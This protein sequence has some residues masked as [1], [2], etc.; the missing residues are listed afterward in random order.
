MPYQAAAAELAKRPGDGAFPF[1][2]KRLALIETADGL[3]LRASFWH[4]PDGQAAQG[5][6]L[7]LQ[8][9]TEFIEKYAEVIAELLER[10][11]AV[12]AFDW[13]GQGLSERQVGN[14]AKGHVEDFDDYL[15]DLAAI[16][17]EMALEAC[18]RPW[19]ML[20]HSMGGG[21]ALLALASGPSPFDRA[22]LSAPLVGLPGFKGHIAS[23]M[24]ARILTSL[25]LSRS[26][27]PGGGPESFPLAE[28]FAN[29]PLTSDEARYAAM[30]DW[31]RIEP[32]LALGAPTIG[33]IDAA[34]IAMERFEEA[35]FGRNNR[36][37]VLMVLAGEDD[38]VS[39][40]AAEALARGF[41][42]ASSITLPGA[43]HEILME[44]DDLRA[45]FWKAFDAFVARAPG[46]DLPALAVQTLEPAKA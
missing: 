37:P 26:F 19:T 39:T 38:V 5:T 24:T 40:R 42:G 13:R 46:E 10:G 31:L 41:R 11:F 6:V 20:A 23:R 22:I 8:G 3:K 27:V 45:L 2:P 17:S 34:F 32:R 30:G 18:P 44:C 35:D 4:P 28:A 9:R 36:T 7:I 33:W 29:N 1:P 25:G 12:V 16:V 15:I 14:P 43:R 21:V